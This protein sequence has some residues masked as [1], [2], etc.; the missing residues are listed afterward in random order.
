MAT[1]P[2]LPPDEAPL[3]EAAV[4]L[5][6]SNM[7]TKLVLVGGQALGFWMSRFA[8]EPV[9]GVAI[10]ND[11]ERHL[12][13][14]EGHLRGEAFQ[15]TVH[16]AAEHGAHQHVRIQRRWREASRPCAS[17]CCCA[18]SFGF[19]QGVEVTNRGFDIVLRQRHHSFE[20][21]RRVAQGLEVDLGGAGRGDEEAHGLAM[22][23]HGNGLLAVDE[24]GQAGAE[25]ADADRLGFHGVLQAMGDK[26]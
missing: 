13:R 16:P 5:L 26:P 21:V 9:E 20:L 10:S 19:A 3:D 14:E 8:I 1:E 23:R 18:R 7:G 2:A 6:L 17:A 15:Q 4:D 24:L 25:L 22:P 12:W 11:G